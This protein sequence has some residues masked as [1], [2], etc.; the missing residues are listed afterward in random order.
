MD[1]VIGK[2]CLSNEQIIEIEGHLL[3]KQDK[4]ARETKKRIRVYQ[5]NEV[6]HTRRVGQLTNDI[7]GLQAELKLAKRARKKKRTVLINKITT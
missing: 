6:Y 7:A 3:C 1:N 4:D 5:S 2:R